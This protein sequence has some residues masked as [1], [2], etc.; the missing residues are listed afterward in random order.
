LSYAELIEYE[1][2]LSKVSSPD[3]VMEVAPIELEAP[4]ASI[5]STDSAGAV[6][7]EKNADTPK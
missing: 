5:H 2:L 7:S 6:P 1:R 4:K 3:R